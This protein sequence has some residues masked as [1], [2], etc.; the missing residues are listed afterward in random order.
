MVLIDA[1]LLNQVERNPVAYLD[2]NGR[3]H[4]FDCGR[5]EFK[6]K[7][8]HKLKAVYLSHFHMDHFSE[9][10]AIIA[11]KLNSP[12]KEFDVFGPV[13]TYKGVVSKLNAYV[14]NLADPS[15]IIINV[16]EID[17][18]KMSEYLVKVPEQI[19]GVHIKDHQ[20]ENGIIASTKNYSVKYI[21]LNHGIPSLGY[22]FEENDT[23]NIDKE[24]LGELDVKPGPWL[25]E[26]KDKAESGDRSEITID[27]KT[28]K[29]EE[30]EHLLF[31]KKGIKVVYLTD[32]IM[33]E[34][35]LEKASSFAKDADLLMC[36]AN[37]VEAD[38]D[39]AVKNYHLTG[40]QAGKLAHA[41]NVKDLVLLHF[42][43]KYE[44]KDDIISEAKQ[45][46]YNVR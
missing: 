37:Y 30:L 42:S 16:F 33:E 45:H 46:F 10:D 31:I 7:F 41:A 25:Q 19:D 39:L 34:G 11:M 36:E 40:K 8:V 23:L 32:F 6:Q 14:W 22:S 18:D 2:Y 3:T 9:F 21:E 5:T 20:I 28:Y 38:I 1:G 13:G 26:F 15:S 44:N 27:E 17:G 24:K 4:L 35:T 12:N 29:Y 43:P